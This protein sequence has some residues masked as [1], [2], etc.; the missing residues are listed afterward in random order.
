MGNHLNFIQRCQGAL[1]D[2][3]VIINLGLLRV[4]LNFCLCSLEVILQKRSEG[5]LWSEVVLGNRRGEQL[6]SDEQISQLQQRL[7]YLTSEDLVS[8]VH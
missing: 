7:S 3:P 2:N 8:F 4:I 1:H 6:M 5:P